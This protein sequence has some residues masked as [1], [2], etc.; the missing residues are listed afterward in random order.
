[1]R[2]FFDPATRVKRDVDSTGTPGVVGWCDRAD[3]PVLSV[4]TVPELIS[5]PGAVLA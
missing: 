5:V 4:A 2:V 3:E 1:M